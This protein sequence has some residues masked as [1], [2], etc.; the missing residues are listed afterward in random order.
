MYRHNCFLADFFPS[1]LFAP[2]SCHLDTFLRTSQSPIFKLQSLLTTLLEQEE[3]SYD[4]EEDHD[5]FLR[6][7]TVPIFCMVALFKSSYLSGLE[8]LLGFGNCLLSGG[9]GKI[10]QSFPVSSCSSTLKTT[11]AVTA[12]KYLIPYSTESTW[13]QDKL[14]RGHNFRRNGNDSI[15]WPGSS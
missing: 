15:E 13:S 3:K 4:D 9:A 6:P 11:C 1:R 8:I 10:Y 12:K 7:V 5:D 2:S 14:P